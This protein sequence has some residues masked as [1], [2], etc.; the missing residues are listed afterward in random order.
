MSDTEMPPAPPKP[1]DAPQGAPGAEGAQGAG[2]PTEPGSAPD[3]A[4]AQ[5][6]GASAASAEIARVFIAP[7]DQEIPVRDGVKRVTKGDYVLSFADGDVHV[8]PPSKFIDL[9]GRP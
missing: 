9:V 4:Q 6:S 1:D 7:N 8:V 3:P 2:A 5:G